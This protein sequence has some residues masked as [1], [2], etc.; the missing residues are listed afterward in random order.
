VEGRKFTVYTDHKP[1]VFALRQNPEK[2]TP[3]QFRYLDFIAQYTT[4]IRY[5]EGE[6]NQAA[7]ALSRIDTLSGVPHL[8]IV[9]IDELAAAQA[10]D[11][12][13][14]SLLL[15]KETSLNLHEIPYAGYRIIC[16][17]SPSGNIRP[18]VPNPLRQRLFQQYHD[19]AHPGIKRTRHLVSSRYVWPSLQK[20]VG[21][22]TRTCINCQRSKIGRHTSAP[23]SPFDPSPHRLDHIHLDLI[24]PLPISNSN[25][26]CLTMIDRASRWPEVV[27]IPDMT[28]ETVAKAFI[29]TWVS[30]FGCPS[31]IT[32]DQGRQFESKLLHILTNAL[33]TKRIRTTS[34]HPQSNGLI[35]NFHRTLKAS[36]TSCPDSPRWSEYLPFILL[37][38]RTA[39]NT[40]YEISPAETLYGQDLRLPGDIFVPN[41]PRDSQE[42]AQ[43]IAHAASLVANLKHHDTHRRS[44]I[45]DALKT[46]S[47]VFLRDD[48][49]KPPLTPAYNGPFKVLQRN[50]KTFSIEIRSAPKEFSIDHLRPAFMMEISAQTAPDTSSHTFQPSGMDG[51][52]RT[53]MNRNVFSSNESNSENNSSSAKNNAKPSSLYVTRAGRQSKPPVRFG[54]NTV[55]FI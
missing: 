51:D 19:T 46:C 11:E 30:R 31:V 42:I 41:P 12:E 40:D 5:I 20:D 21:N 17:V 22:W 25:R 53:T 47:H 48:R 16:D 34:Y 54:T 35:E 36:I 1:I 10:N 15:T 23:V 8:N 29:D 2:A 43:R 9:S 33:G 27:P 55:H 39:I 44:Y 13:L 37:I 52:H 26:Y 14:K 45:P 38:L 49:V 6:K 28:A 32:T 3:R 4:D 18:F 7:D 50:E 24:G